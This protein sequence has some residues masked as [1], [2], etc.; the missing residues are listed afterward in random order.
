MR[1][2]VLNGNVWRVVRVEP[3]DP[4]LIDRGGV[5]RIAVADPARRMIAI[6]RHVLSPLLDR[7]LLHEIGHAVTMEHGFRVDEESAQLIEGHSVEAVTL[8]SEVL[9]RPVCIDGKCLGS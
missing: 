1:P 2:F 8:A 5:P 3:D 7:V 9:G 6:S 4:Y